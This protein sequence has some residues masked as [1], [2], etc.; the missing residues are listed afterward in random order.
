M[1]EGCGASVINSKWLITALHCVAKNL[2]VPPHL[3]E[4]Y[5]VESAR[6]FLGAH[7][8]TEAFAAVGLSNLEKKT[9]SQGNLK[10]ERLALGF[11]LSVKYFRIFNASSIFLFRDWQ[12]IALVQVQGTININVFTP[13][14]LPHLG[15]Q[16]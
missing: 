5:S 7:N 15:L 14:C 2:S 16:F 13:I 10:Y 8:I 3:L 12:D 6:I 9:E 1:L 4:T 11:L